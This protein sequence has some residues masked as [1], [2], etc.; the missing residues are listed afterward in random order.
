MTLTSLLES[1]TN[2]E[3]DFIAGLDYG[4]GSNSH[5]SALDDVIA[6]GGLVDFDLAGNW[7]PFEVIELGKNWLQAGHER[8]YAACLGMFLK[9]IE[10]GADE[11]NELEWIVEN[12]S[13][14]ISRLP[15]E[16]N[17]LITALI[18]NMINHANKS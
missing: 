1:L 16:L 2:D 18:D 17:N 7:Y 11:L 3:R 5:R 10:S 4:S 14:S 13:D 6:S 12:Q 8:E 15:D 9:N